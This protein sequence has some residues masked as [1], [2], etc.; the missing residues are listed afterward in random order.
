MRLSSLSAISFT[1]LAASASAQY[2][3][4]GPFLTQPASN[5]AVMKT[6]ICATLPVCTGIAQINFRQ[7]S[8]T[9][10]YCCLT[11]TINASV[12][13][14]VYAGTWNSAT[15]TFV[16]L[17]DAD[18]FNALAAPNSN[19]FALA[20]SQDGLTAVCDTAGSTYYATRANTGVA[21]GTP[22]PIGG[23]PAGGYLDSMLGRLKGQLTDFYVSGQDIYS[24]PI[25]GGVLGTA[26]KVVTNPI[27][28]SASHSPSTMNDA[29]GESR[30]LLFASNGATGADAMYTAGFNDLSGK[31]LLEN[32]SAWINNGG[33][34]GGTCYY[35]DSTGNYVTNGP[36]T[37]GMTCTGST[38]VPNAGG[39]ITLTNFAPFQA[40]ANV[41][42]L[43][44]MLLG[45]L[46]GSG[47]PIPGINGNL[48]LSLL[49]LVSV[50]FPSHN[51]DN[52]LSQIT[53]SVGPLPPG[54]RVD[55]QNVMLDLLASKAYLGSSGQLDIL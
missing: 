25:T 34:I 9:S 52:G 40:S 43:S 49:G 23:A 50:N 8:G 47:T 55:Y 45:S 14:L 32:H 41:P 39:P 7:L 16:K 54:G 44:A 35:A 4:E 26:T 18:S 42:Y 36:R 17:T 33:A 51:N 21:F 53:F 6:A 38:T 5:L 30:A 28:F 46:N 22:L 37:W 1:V 24:A 13:T 27:G 11:A 15:N 12:G 31:F 19:P 2:Q 20:V 48:A 3:G 10:F 29:T